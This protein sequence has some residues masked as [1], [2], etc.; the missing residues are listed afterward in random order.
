M[1]LNGYFNEYRV[2]GGRA[3]IRFISMSSFEISDIQRCMSSYLDISFDN[4]KTKGLLVEVSMFE[5]KRAY[6][7][8]KIDPVK[9]LLSLVK[10]GNV[11]LSMEPI[12]RMPSLQV[13]SLFYGKIMYSIELIC[14]DS[15]IDRERFY[16]MLFESLGYPVIINEG[17]THDMAENVFHVVKTIASR[18]N[19]QGIEEFSPAANVSN[20]IVDRLRKGLC[21][22]C[23]SK[24]VQTHKGMPL[25]DKHYAEAMKN[26]KAFK[27]KYHL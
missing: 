8:L 2:A 14:K 19:I 21:S 15:E 17:M 16:D 11:C 23:A 24:Y 20:F 1:E 4:I 6:L 12:N 7:N 13:D 9:E 10:V 3:Y 27:E 22:C 26:V 18:M 5:P 25:C